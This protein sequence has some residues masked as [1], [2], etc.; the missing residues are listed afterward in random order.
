MRI[1]AWQVH[2]TGLVAAPGSFRRLAGA[3]RHHRGQGEPWPERVIM[4]LVDDRLVVTTEHATVI[5]EWPVGDVT[6]RR[7]TAGPPVTFVVQLPGEARL[8]AAAAGPDIDAMLAA[9]A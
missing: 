7:V 6:L 5:G 8:V 2:D 3:V 4:E 9:M 1:E